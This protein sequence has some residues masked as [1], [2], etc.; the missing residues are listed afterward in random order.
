MVLGMCPIGTYPGI[1]EAKAL[2]MSSR[3]REERD[4]AKDVSTSVKRAAKKPR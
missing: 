2:G 3:A 4:E 1:P